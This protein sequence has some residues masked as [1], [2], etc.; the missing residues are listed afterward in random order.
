MVT[1]DNILAH[2][3]EDIRSYSGCDPAAAI[4]E[5]LVGINLDLHIAITTNI[6]DTEFDFIE[7]Y[8]LGHAFHFRLAD[9]EHGKLLAGQMFWVMLGSRTDMRLNTGEQ[10][11]PED[12]LY[13]Y[14]H[15]TNISPSLKESVKQQNSSGETNKT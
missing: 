8:G 6:E 10:F 2:I 14:V 9:Y 13:L 15:L 5:F 3:A 12:R 1:I 4:E 7:R 11:N